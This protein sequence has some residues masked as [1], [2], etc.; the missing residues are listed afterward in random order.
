MPLIL[1]VMFV[2]GGLGIATLIVAKIQANNEALACQQEYKTVQ[3]GLDAYMAYLDVTTVPPGSTNN[4]TVSPDLSHS[5]YSPSEPLAFLNTPTVY[6][7]TWDSFGR[8]TT[9][10]QRSG[11]PSVPPGCV[12]SSG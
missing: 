10:S 7:Y 9:I 3:A 5:L 6:T 8:I 4:W 1:A 11:G 12:V 2:A